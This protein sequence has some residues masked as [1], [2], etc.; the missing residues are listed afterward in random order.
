MQSDTAHDELVERMARAICN[1]RFGGWFWDLAVPSQKDDW[2]TDARAALAV[3]RPV[4]REE[5]AR[6]VESSSVS[7]F[8]QADI[9]KPLAPIAAAI[10]AME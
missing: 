6:V 9:Q 7:V 1:A 5:C 10:T 3:A 2:R 8:G 4:I